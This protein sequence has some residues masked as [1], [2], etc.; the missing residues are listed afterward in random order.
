M[1]L[2]FFTIFENGHYAADQVYFYESNSKKLAN[3]AERAPILTNLFLTW[4]NANIFVFVC[5]SLHF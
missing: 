3:F 4:S 5:L 2:N 1:K